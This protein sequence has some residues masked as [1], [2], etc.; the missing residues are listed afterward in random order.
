[1]EKSHKIANKYQCK[2]CDYE[3]CNS[4]DYTRHVRTR[5]HQNRTVSTNFTQKNAEQ[6]IC[7][8]CNKCYKARNSLWYHQQKCKPIITHADESDNFVIDKEFVM[9]ILKQN[10]DIIKENSE[11]T[12]QLLEKQKSTQ[13]IMLEI[14]KAQNLSVSSV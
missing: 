10:A 11:L 3:T 5:K 13:Q 1:M 6:F 12:N 8:T 14:I 2:I 7:N 4:A 9:S